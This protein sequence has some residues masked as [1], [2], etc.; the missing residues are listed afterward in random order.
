MTDTA[1]AQ[2]LVARDTL[3]PSLADWRVHRSGTPFG[4]PGQRD[5]Q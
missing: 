3:T 5:I 4:L 1:R 2:L